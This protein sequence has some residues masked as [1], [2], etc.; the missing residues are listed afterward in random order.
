VG[1]AVQGPRR[2]IPEEAQAR[3]GVDARPYDGYTCLKLTLCIS[4]P[5]RVELPAMAGTWLCRAASDLGQP[6]TS[7]R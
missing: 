6:A 2:N 4:E 3:A 1:A 7:I 5:I